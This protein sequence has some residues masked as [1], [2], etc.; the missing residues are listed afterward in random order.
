MRSQGYIENYFLQKHE[1]SYACGTKPL[2][3]ALLSEKPAAGE[4][5]ETPNYLMYKELLYRYTT[6]KLVYIV[7]TL[8]IVFKFV[9]IFSTTLPSKVESFQQR[10]LQR[11][12]ELAKLCGCSCFTIASNEVIKT[13]NIAKPRTFAALR[14]LDCIKNKFFVAIFYSIGFSVYGFNKRRIEIFG[15]DFIRVILDNMGDSWFIFCSTFKSG[16]DFH[17]SRKR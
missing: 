8:R 12:L 14:K 5:M 15:R 10:L 11:R 4:M 3:K 16:V 13:L 6:I 1:V 7:S 17:E 9:C 2:G